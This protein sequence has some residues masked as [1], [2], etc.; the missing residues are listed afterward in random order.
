MTRGEA[1]PLSDRAGSVSPPLELALGVAEVTARPLPFRVNTPALPPR[2][3]TPALP[4][5]VNTPALAL[6]ALTPPAWHPALRPPAAAAISSLCRA[7]RRV[8]G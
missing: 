8:R 4:P 1:V 5:R 7:S 2:V 3:N 6:A